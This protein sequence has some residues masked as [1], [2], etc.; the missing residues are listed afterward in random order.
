MKPMSRR[1]VSYTLHVTL[2]EFGDS[3]E[4]T[5]RTRDHVEFVL[6]QLVQFGSTIV[7]MPHENGSTWTASCR[8]IEI[9]KDG[10]HVEALG[11]RLF[12]RGRS[13]ERVR[14]KVATL[15]RLGA[16]LEGG[17]CR[18]GEFHSAVCHN[19]SVATSSL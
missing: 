8:R 10:V 11:N 16:H 13:L 14:A 2:M 3:I 15:A 1:I 19:P 5:G 6:G 18:I 12:V 4:I 7:Q 17:I 9:E